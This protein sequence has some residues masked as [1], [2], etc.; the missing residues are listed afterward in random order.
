MA[1][2][3]SIALIG[4]VYTLLAPLRHYSIDWISVAVSLSLLAGVTGTALSTTR[5]RAQNFF[6]GVS[7]VLSMAGLIGICWLFFHK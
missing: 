3:G 2:A 4:L 6:S 7:L 5:K 1:C